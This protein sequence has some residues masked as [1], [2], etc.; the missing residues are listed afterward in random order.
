[1]T[2]EEIQ[3]V[4]IDQVTRVYNGRPGCGCG[5][6]GKYYPEVEGAEPTAHDRGMMTRILRLVKANPAASGKDGILF[7]ETTRNYWVY[8]T[9]RS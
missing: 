1:M 5:C 4:T 7:S 9:A 2:A 6:R 8:L 3:Q